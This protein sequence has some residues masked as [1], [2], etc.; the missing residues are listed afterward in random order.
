MGPRA[1]EAVWP[2]LGV[3]DGRGPSLGRGRGQGGRVCLS[4]SGSWVRAAQGQAG[5]GPAATVCGQLGHNQ[6]PGEKEAACSLQG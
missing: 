4:G 1:G 6:L 2:F 5:V 3:G